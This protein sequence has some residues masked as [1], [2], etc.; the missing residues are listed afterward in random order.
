MTRA[1][2]RR[3]QFQMSHGA[4]AGGIAL[5]TALT[6]L[7]HLTSAGA[8]D[9]PPAP[10]MNDSEMFAAVDSIFADFALDSH[11]PGFVYGIVANGRLVH[12]SGGLTNSHPRTSTTRT[13]RPR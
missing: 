7:I 12:G 13:P 3:N 5:A 10:L 9:V 1:G 8:A 4:R 6:L 11:I 2:Q